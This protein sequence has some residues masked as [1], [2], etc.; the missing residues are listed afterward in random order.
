MNNSKAIDFF[1]WKHHYFEHLFPIWDSL[2]PKYKGNFYVSTHIH[3]IN[4]F[5]IPTIDDHFK[6]SSNL[7]HIIHELSNRKI[8]FLLFLVCMVI[9]LIQLI[10]LLL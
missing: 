7:Q 1:A 5:F 4:Q 9:L 3:E 8:D 2:P 10:D 6:I